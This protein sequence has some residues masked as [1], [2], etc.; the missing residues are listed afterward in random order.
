MRANIWLTLAYFLPLVT[1]SLNL[2][3]A[4]NRFT[5]IVS[6][7]LKGLRVITLGSVGESNK[8]Y[9]TFK[10]FFV[11]FMPCL[12]NMRAYSVLLSCTLD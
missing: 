3:R 4:Q 9:F 10:E 11:R 12:L 6:A 1:A 8:M 2:K 7:R 5:F